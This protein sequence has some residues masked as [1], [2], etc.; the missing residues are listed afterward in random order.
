[1]K[2]KEIFNNLCRKHPRIGPLL[3]EIEER[4][5]RQANMTKK[6]KTKGGKNR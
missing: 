5:K 2:D 1:M 4:D 3:R 6:V